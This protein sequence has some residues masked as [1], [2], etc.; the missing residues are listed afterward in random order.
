M[1]GVYR[2]AEVNVP[3]V[4]SQGGAMVLHMLQTL[5]RAGALPAPLTA[6][7]VE[8]LARAMEATD[9]ARG[10][11][12][13]DRFFEE[14]FLEGWLTS[15][16]TGFT[17]HLSTAD[18]HG[19]AIGVTSSLGE[20]AGFIVEE[21]GVIPNNFLGEEDVNPERLSRPH[22]AR[23]LTMCCPTVVEHE[24]GFLVMGSGGSSRG[25]PRPG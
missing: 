23:L 24:R 11:D 13:I 5:E 20:T 14:G 1:K 21:T 7:H 3:G 22:G 9:V 16:F 25:G 17:T 15:S 10:P 18:E 6:A 2:G 12:H 4:P 8:R 19:N